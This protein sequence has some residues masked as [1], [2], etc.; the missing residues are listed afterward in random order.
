MFLVGCDG[1]TTTSIDTNTTDTL[2]TT[3]VSESTTEHGSTT[4]ENGTTTSSAATTTT[5]Y[6]STTTTNGETTT[7]VTNPSFWREEWPDISEGL[8]AN[9]QHF[10][11]IPNDDGEDGWAIQNA[12][13]FAAGEKTLAQV[14]PK[15]MPETWRTYYQFWEDAKTAQVTGDWSVLDKYYLPLE[16]VDK[17]SY[18]SIIIV[19]I[20]LALALIIGTIYMSLRREK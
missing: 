1:E 18:A 16:T 4:T 10:G 8:V 19:G 11:A 2:Y 13:D 14:A 3:T 5:E 15:D 7:T 12:I 17:Q 20:V 9:V 6:L